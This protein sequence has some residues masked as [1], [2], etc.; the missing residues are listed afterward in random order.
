MMKKSEEWLPVGIIIL[1]L[2]SSGESILGIGKVLLLG[3]IVAMTIIC[4]GKQ[5]DKKRRHNHEKTI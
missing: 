3:T 1:S 2:Y 5:I 4:L